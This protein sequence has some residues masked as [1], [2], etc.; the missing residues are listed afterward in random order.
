MM[1]KGAAD[2]APFLFYTS[3]VKTDRNHI[4]SLDAISYEQYGQVGSYR[5]E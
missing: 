3:I 2:A 5:V 4:C 1:K